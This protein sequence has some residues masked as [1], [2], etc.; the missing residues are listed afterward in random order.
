LGGERVTVSYDQSDYTTG[1]SNSLNITATL[2]VC[3]SGCSSTSIQGAIVGATAGDTISVGAGTYIETGQIV[4]AQNLTIVGA[5][6]GATTINPAG[7]TSGSYYDDSSAWILVDAGVTFNLSG[8]T[9]DGTGRMIA[10]ALLSHGSGTIS[11]NVIE[12]IGYNESGPDYDG[13]GI[14]LY[15]A[16]MTVSS[17]TFSDIGRE[18]VFAAFL[19]TA[20]ITGNTYTGKGN[21]NWLD[22]AF[23][24]GRNS[25][26][27]ISGNTVTGNTGVATVDGSTSAGIIVDTYYNVA[28]PTTSA[29]ITN[30]TITG[31]YDGVVVGYVGSDQS[32]VVAHN[33]N[34]SDNSDT[35]IF[36][37]NPVVDATDNW[38]GS[39]SGPYNA[40][41]N[42]SG[43]GSAVTANIL[44][45]NWCTT[46][47]CPSSPSSPPSSSATTGSSPGSATVT[48]LDP[49]TNG[50]SSLT[51]FVV[52]A[53]DVTTGRA[54]SPVSIGPSATSTTLTGLRGGDSFTFAVA[55]MNEVAA[56]PSAT[57]N[58]VTV[59]GSPPPPPPP[60]QVTPAV[61]PPP[62]EVPISDLGTPASS[63]ASSTVPV[64]D[65]V[66]SGTS[67]SVVTVPAGAL[68]TGTV[69]T[70][71]PITNT[72]SLQAQI[73]PGNSYVASIAVS[74]QAP[75]GSSPATT[76]GLVI[77]LTITDP[78]IRA[79]DVIYEVTSAGL[80]NV[81]TATVD[82]SVT[83]SFTTDPVFMITAKIL[84]AQAVLSV[85]STSGT[86]GTALRL[87]TSGGSGTGAVSYTV[88]DGTA[89]GCVV[90]NGSI[91]VT[92]AGTCVIAATKATDGTYYAVS[93]AAVVTFDLATDVPQAPLRVTSTS[94]TGGTALALTTSGGSGTGAVSYSVMTGTASGC[95]I[96]SGALT[97]TSAGTCVV[98]ATK[99]AD[100]TYVSV[101]SLATVVT[102]SLGRQ[103][104]LSVTS[105]IGTLGTALTLTT[106]G[107]SGTGAVSYTVI[108][109]TANGC[110][111]LN[112]S[113]SVTGA[114][115][116]IV[117]ATK[118]G[119][120][121]YF[122]E[123]SAP[124]VVTL[125]KA[126]IV[127]PAAAVPAP[128]MVTFTFYSSALSF[129][130]RAVL[131]DL[132]KKLARGASVTLVGYADFDIPLAT[133]RAVA[134]EKF[135]RGLV[136]VKVKI[137]IV[138]KLP[139][140]KV[141]VI[142]TAT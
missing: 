34:L 128:I 75:D 28:G 17:N 104:A 130:T 88:V 121:T 36:S 69:V 134:V 30:N 107:G 132:S 49:V 106:S 81:G 112:G 84:L 138:T 131:I 5:G 12:N 87:I 122:G 50:G 63:N 53:F 27:T 59:L 79:G 47:T 72:V 33:N 115:T 23:E 77:T 142:T 127:K 13:A 124:T 118:A 66:T 102:L 76:S 61:A 19:S 80:T 85:T 123:S 129:S 92:V 46:M 93:T 110:A 89:S 31:N 16:T 39:A 54:G 21:G 44:D 26:A 60:L 2:T 56:G 97:A 86:V 91:S 51:G 45:A 14:A 18:G 108:D 126:V 35:G 1:V 43:A 67:S 71:Y 25:T 7:N 58:P 83:I 8:V 96:A 119:D 40:T 141:K 64:T 136:Q 105:T 48:W 116:C 74:W 117:I 11:N 15:G 125:I 4:I 137:Q 62:A 99:A 73:P 20:T 22:Y 38:W 3:A 98:T 111:F 32:V 9:L 100:A 101:S 41:A 29:T 70:T 94:G 37:T 95:S 133:S 10:N 135:L 90:L 139:I 42:P 57:S 103:A 120:S 6:A 113:I 82:G 140:R 78:N 52:V 55:A 24:I 114:G 109:G 68:P 65:T